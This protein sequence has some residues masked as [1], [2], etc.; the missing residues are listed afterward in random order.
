[1]NKY[2]PS[3]ETFDAVETV[4]L[5][6]MTKK[7]PENFSDDGKLRLKPVFEALGGKVSYDDIRLSMVFLK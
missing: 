7:M 5:K 1:M 6:F 2:K 3:E 4:A